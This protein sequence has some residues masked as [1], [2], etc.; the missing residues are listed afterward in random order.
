M[1]LRVYVV[2]L[3]ISFVYSWIDKHLLN[4]SSSQVFFDM[5]YAP[6]MIQPGV[7]MARQ[8][9]SPATEQTGI[10]EYHHSV[11]AADHLNLPMNRIWDSWVYCTINDV[12]VTDF[13]L[14]SRRI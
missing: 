7:K 14:L 9:S 1:Q 13:W 4:Y 8:G 2:L 5:R 3:F 10:V 6:T 11:N 12:V